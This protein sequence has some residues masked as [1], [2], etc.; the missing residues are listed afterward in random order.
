MAENLIQIRET[1]QDKNDKKLIE[2]WLWLPELWRN[3]K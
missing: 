1:L 3:E 2:N